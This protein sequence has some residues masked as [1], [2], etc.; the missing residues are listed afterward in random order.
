[1][2]QLDIYDECVLLV[3]RRL[4]RVVVNDYGTVVGYLLFNPG[5]RGDV[6]RG[7]EVAPSI[8]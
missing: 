1:M 4:L 2:V 6:R 7:D 8:G 5:L 3:G